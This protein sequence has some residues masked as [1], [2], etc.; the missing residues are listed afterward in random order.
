VKE[1]AGQHR[2]GLRTQEPSPRGVGVAERRWR[3]PSPHE[4]PADGRG[5]D[6]MTEF[7]QLTLDSLETPRRVV[8]S[9][10][11][12]ECREVLIHWRAAEPVG[13]GPLLRHQAAVPT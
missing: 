2:R 10:P 5:T 6:A 12:N 4:D 8:P 11:R 1:I 7:E 3:D 9:Q 13:M